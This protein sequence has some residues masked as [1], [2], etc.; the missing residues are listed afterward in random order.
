MALDI[1]QHCCVITHT[2][3]IIN[4]KKNIDN[5]YLLSLQRRA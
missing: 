2:V 3:I 4:S 1:L 5:N